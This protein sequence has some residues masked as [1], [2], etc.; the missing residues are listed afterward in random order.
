MKRILVPIDGSANAMRALTYVL[1]LFRGDKVE[2]ML[3]QSFDIPTYTVDMPVPIDVVGAEELKR[4]LDK[5][6][7]DLKSDFSDQ[8][9]QFTTLVEQGALSFNVEQLVEREKIDLVVMGTKGASGLSAALIGTNTVDVIQT[10]TCPLLVVPDSVNVAANP[11]KILFA[12][13]NKGL[14]DSLVIAP[15][16]ELASKFNSHVH[17]MNVLDEGKMTTVDEAVAGLKL[18]HMLEKLEHTFYFETVMIRYMP[19]KSIW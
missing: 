2:F 15:V 13:D 3:F 8:E 12:S 19:L 6:V 10:T 16:I 11:V 5:L 17:I 14:S 18:D 9:Y 4:V 7:S 1:N